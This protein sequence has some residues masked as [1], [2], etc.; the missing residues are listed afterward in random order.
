MTNSTKTLL[1]TGKPLDQQPGKITFFPSPSLVTL[2]TYKIIFNLVL[3][4]HFRHDINS[5]CL[6]NSTKNKYKNLLGGSKMKK[7]LSLLAM[8]A[9]LAGLTGCLDPQDGEKQKVS[10]STSSIQL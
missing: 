6:T 8:T 3:H 9:I 2:T 10:S 4:Q 7:V 5:A 1:E